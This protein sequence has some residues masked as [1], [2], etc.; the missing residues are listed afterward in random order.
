MKEYINRLKLERAIEESRVTGGNIDDIYE[1]LG[2][3]Y[4][5]IETAVAHT[6]PKTPEKKLKAT[7]D[8][9]KAKKK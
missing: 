1:R 9:I 8:K 6:T 2:G 4:N 7:L 5:V 3:K